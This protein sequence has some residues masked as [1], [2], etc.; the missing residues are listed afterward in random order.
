LP[1]ICRTLSKIGHSTSF[2]V[3][4]IGVSRNP[5]R[6]VVVRYNNVDL[7]SETYEDI[8]TG[9]LQIRRFQPP[10]SGLTTVDSEKPSNI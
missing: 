9:K 6:G 1:N 5:E 8:A 2:K 7:I 4:P 3:I 10:H